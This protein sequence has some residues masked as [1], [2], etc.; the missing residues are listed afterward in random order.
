MCSA[1]L[2]WICRVWIEAVH[3]Q[4]RA[5]G[6]G[7]TFRMVRYGGIFEI[8]RGIFATLIG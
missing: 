1:V 5:C 3:V 2:L 4:S 8:M 7:R 6:D